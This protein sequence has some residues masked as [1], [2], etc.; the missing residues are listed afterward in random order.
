MSDAQGSLW[1]MV[2]HSRFEIGNFAFAFV[3]F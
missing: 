2:A 3:N 1:D